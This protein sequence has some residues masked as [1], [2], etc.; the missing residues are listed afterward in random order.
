MLCVLIYKLAKGLPRSYL[1]N[2][3]AYLQR[4]SALPCQSVLG[5][6]ERY[7][8]EERIGIAAS[9]WLEPLQL[10]HAG[11]HKTRTQCRLRPAILPSKERPLSSDPTRHGDFD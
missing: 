8:A 1:S 2:A 9:A 10:G 4:K 5:V 11:R 6:A 7:T 3:V